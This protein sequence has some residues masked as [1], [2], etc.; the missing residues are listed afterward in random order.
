M[1][2]RYKWTEAEL[3]SYL[4][5]L[6]VL[7]WAGLWL[8][9]PALARLLGLGDLTIACLAVCTTSLGRRSGARSASRLLCQDISCPCSRRPPSGCGWAAWCWTGSVS[10][11]RCVS[12]TPSTWWSTGTV[13]YSTVQYSE[14]S[15]TVSLQNRL[16]GGQQ[17][18][19]DSGINS[20][21]G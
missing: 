11:G 16:N 13:Q 6:R 7:C 18:R 12:S 8:L 1:C 19:Q 17:I 9:T 15:T 14:Y 5:V 3:S 20:R 2:A 10:A 21:W 4:L